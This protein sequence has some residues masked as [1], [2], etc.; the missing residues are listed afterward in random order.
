MGVT[1]FPPARLKDVLERSEG[2]CLEVGQRGNVIDFKLNGRPV[3]PSRQC[4]P[5]AR[6]GR[7]R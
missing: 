1:R 3:G 6:S 5:K 2:N 7:S 4:P